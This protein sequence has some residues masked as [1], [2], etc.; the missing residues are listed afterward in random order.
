MDG[1]LLPRLGMLSIVT[2]LRHTTPAAGRQMN[3]VEDD[4]C[5]GGMGRDE[6]WGMWTD[7][8]KQIHSKC[9]IIL[10]TLSV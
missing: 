10:I 4:V 1:V 9:S 8:M 7:M 2:L 5:E 3:A 6:E